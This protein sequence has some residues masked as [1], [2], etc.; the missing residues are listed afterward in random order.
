MTLGDL[1]LIVDL[2]HIYFVV[3]WYLIIYVLCS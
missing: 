2:E 1:G 3:P